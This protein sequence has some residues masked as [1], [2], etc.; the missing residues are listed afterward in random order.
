[1]GLDG[2]HAAFFIAHPDE[3]SFHLTDAG[4]AAMHAAAYGIDLNAKRL[5]QLNL[6]PGISL[7]RFDKGG[8]IIA[9]G[10]AGRL[11][12]AIWEAV[13]LATALSFQ[14]SAEHTSELQSLMRTS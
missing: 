14:R 12:E 5:E 1:M 11:Q 7:A 4:E 10:P 6:A 13:K 9:S 2:Q 3:H 8:A